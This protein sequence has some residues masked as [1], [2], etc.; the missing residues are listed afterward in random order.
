MSDPY[1]R[2]T[3][4]VAVVLLLAVAGVASALPDCLPDCR[5]ATLA[6]ADLS[7]RLAEGHRLARRHFC[8]SMTAFFAKSNAWFRR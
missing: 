6:G 2:V 5:G 1:R 7:R 4:A 3:A 8:Q